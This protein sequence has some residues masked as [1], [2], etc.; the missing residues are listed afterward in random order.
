MANTNVKIRS[1]S[2]TDSDKLGLLKTGKLL[3]VVRYL[4]NGWYKVSF[5]GKDAYVYSDYVDLGTKV[6]IKR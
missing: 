6:L 1:E 5:L 2:N 3:E 4:D